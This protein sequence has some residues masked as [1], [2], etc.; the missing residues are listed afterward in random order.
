[1]RIRALTTSTRRAWRPYRAAQRLRARFCG[2]LG[3]LDPLCLVAITYETIIGNKWRIRAQ[4]LRAAQQAELA[5]IRLVR[6]AR[7]D[8]V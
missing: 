6:I 4:Q 2:G 3:R 1:M 7:Q 8:L 5:A